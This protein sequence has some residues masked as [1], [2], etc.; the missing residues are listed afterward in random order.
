MRLN[1]FLAQYTSLSRR[2]ADRAISEGRVNINGI[3]A[4]L[5]DVVIDIDKITLDMQPVISDIKI[6]TLVLN[7]PIGYVCSKSGQGSKTIYELLPPNLHYINSVGRLD[8]DSSGLLVMT[9][10]GVLAN[11]MTHPRYQK[12]KKYI[13]ILDRSLEPLH[14]QMI[15]DHGINL[16]DGLSKLGLVSNDKNAKEWEV[17]MS[18][19]R[20][21]QIRRT[22]AALGYEVKKLHR[23]HFGPYLL[24]DLKLGNYKV[25]N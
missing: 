14:H 16:A 8:K 3:A 18:E 7:K 9:N 10:D 23:T 1:K 12:Q 22:F 17:T 20:N 21:R 11:Q 19:G 5:G 25:T 24:G 13:I 2:S 6:T 4:K 15:A